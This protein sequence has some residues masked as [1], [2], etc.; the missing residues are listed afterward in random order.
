MFFHV[1]VFYVRVRIFH[2]FILFLFSCHVLSSL[3]NTSLR[4]SFLMF[5]HMICS[6][7][8]FPTPRVLCFCHNLPNGIFISWFVSSSTSCAFSLFN[9]SPLCISFLMSSSSHRLCFLFVSYFYHDLPIYGFH[10]LVSCIFSLSNTSLL[11]I[12]FLMSSSF[13]DFFPLMSFYCLWSISLSTSWCHRLINSFSHI[14][15]LFIF[16]LL[17]IASPHT[18]LINFLHSYSPISSAFF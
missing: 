3:L 10:S 2:V 7:S 4:I 17:D 16:S 9:A 15:P 5:L 1:L 8:Y 18:L 11:R 13:L 6:H 12:S 14:L